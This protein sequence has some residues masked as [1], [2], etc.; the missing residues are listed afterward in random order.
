MI[1]DNDPILLVGGHLGQRNA[2]FRIVTGREGVFALI[3]GID[4]VEIAIDHHLPGNLHSVA[5]DRGEDRTILL[6]VV[7]DLAIVRQRHGILTVT[8]HIAGARVFLD[9]QAVHRMLVRKLNDL[10]AFHDIETDARDAGI[11]LVV[12]ENVAAI[13]G[14]VGEGDMRVMQVAVHV[15]AAAIL[16]E[17]AGLGKKP[18]GQDLQT[19]VGLAPAGR[20]AAVEYRHAHQFAHRR[21]PDNAHFSGLA[22]GEEGVIFVEFARGYFSLLDRGPRCRRFRRRRLGLRVRSGDKALAVRGER[23]SARKAHARCCRSGPEQGTPA[24]ASFRFRCRS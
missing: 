8:E 13:I 24:D 21:K 3:V 12:H 1:E 9:A 10:I 14:A 5:I 2:L 15:G 7:E 19:L 22:A 11:G 6:A 17:F 4:I 20:A 16:E 18:L 23:N